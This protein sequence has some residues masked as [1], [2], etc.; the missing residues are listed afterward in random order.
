MVRLLY[1]KNSH[2]HSALCQRQ[3]SACHRYCAAL[4]SV[5]G[6]ASEA[7]SVLREGSAWGLIFHCRGLCLFS[8]W[9]ILFCA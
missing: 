4:Y 2:P 1:I 6:A 3:P 8:A 9:D 7:G 5:G